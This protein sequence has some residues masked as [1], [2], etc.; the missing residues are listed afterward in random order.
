MGT[1]GIN[2]GSATSG[3]GFDVASTVTQIQASAQAIETPW[4]NQLTALQA[5]DTILSNLG[6]DLAALTTSLQ[7]LTDFSGVFS[8]K[9]G[10][11]SNTNV[12]SLSSADA[13]AS[14][15]SHTIVVTSLAQTSSQASSAVADPNDT[16]SGSLTIQGHT[17][18]VDSADNDTTLASLA[19]AINSAGIGVKANVITDSTG[20]RLSLVSGT[21]GVAGQLS[22]TASLSGASAGALTFSSSQDGKDAS[23]TVDGVA[24]TTGSN[25]VSNA[26]PGVTFQLLGSSP[27]TQIQVEITNNNTDVE[28]AV[29]KFVAAY[30]AV[31]NDING[32]EKNDSSGQPEPLFGNPTLALIQSQITG[33]LFTGAA[34]GAITNITQLGIGLNND[35][36]LTLNADTLDSA[37]NSNFSDVSGFLQNSGSFGQKMASSLNNLGTQAP[38]GAIYLAQQQN[39]AQE[40]ALNTSISN[41]DTLLAAQKVQLTNELNTANQILQS[42]PSQLNQINEI[43]SAITGYNQNRTG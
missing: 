17:F 40:K 16:I 25:T 2:F 29:G 7:A 21:S 27:G 41:E 12:L 38:N 31:V 36:T 4:K 37:L 14:A 3:Q 42:I 22:V 39:S 15:G 33:S 24:I 20:S 28:T 34:S 30:N 18:N 8:E 26:I 11:S 5:Q 35:G 19:S 6:S 10:S 9:Q 23:L 32:Q 43:Y 13:T 1:V